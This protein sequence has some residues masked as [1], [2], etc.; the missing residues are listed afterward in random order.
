[1]L[2]R[3]AGNSSVSNGGDLSG[4]ITVTLREL[5]SEMDRKTSAE[6]DPIVL[7][8]LLRMYYPQF[9]EKNNDGHFIQQVT[10]YSNI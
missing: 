8:Q 4:P 5:Y 10:I 2:F 9:N 6:I 1:M 3:F 7:V